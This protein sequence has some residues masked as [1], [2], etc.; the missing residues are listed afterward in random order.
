[1]PAKKEKTVKL[2]V[3]IANHIHAGKL[4]RVGDEISVSESAAK[5]LKMNW[6]TMLKNDKVT[7]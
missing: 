1:M 5:M 4:C 6:G 2:K 3:E 7:K